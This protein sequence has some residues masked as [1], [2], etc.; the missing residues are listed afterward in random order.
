MTHPRKRLLLVAAL[1]AATIASSVPAQNRRIVEP[2]MAMITTERAFSRMSEE[3]GIRESFTEFIAEDGI[4]FRPRAVFGK[5]WMRENPLPPST[6]RPLLVWQPIVAGM[7]RAGDLGYTT[8]PWQFKNDIKDAKFSAF[9]TFMT[10]WKKQPDGKWKF[11]VDLG[12][13]NPEPKTPA[14]LTYGEPASG[15]FARDAAMGRSTLQ[16]TE[17]DFSKASVKRGAVE[18]FLAYASPD[19]RVFRNQKHPFIGRKVAVAAWTPLSIELSWTMQ[20]ADVS[21][22]GDIGYSY[23]LYEMRDKATN[24]IT[25]TGNYMRVWK[26]VNGAWK[27][28]LDLTDPH[29]PEKKS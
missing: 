21:T 9:G 2:L 15:R 22:S 16:D 3:K 29:P 28:I 27:L 19:V 6:A 1:V 7:S 17:R 11:V 26:R 8:G 4:L 20:S 23:G 13:S 5:K 12:V 24:S 10:V 18:A 25:E 14:L